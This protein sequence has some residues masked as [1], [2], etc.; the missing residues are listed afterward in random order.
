MQQRTQSKH[1]LSCLSL[2]P[3]AEAVAPA[4]VLSL[5]GVLIYQMAHFKITGTLLLDE[6]QL[7]LAMVAITGRREKKKVAKDAKFIAFISFIITV[8]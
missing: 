1:R 7:D 4:S 6:D 8:K 5:A 3:S 2:L